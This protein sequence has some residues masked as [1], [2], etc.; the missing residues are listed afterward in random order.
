MRMSS[1]VASVHPCLK[2]PVL[3]SATDILYCLGAFVT[4]DENVP[5]VL[6]LHREE[7]KQLLAGQ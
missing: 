6:I 7:T 3:F 4:F 5:V 1:R 2:A